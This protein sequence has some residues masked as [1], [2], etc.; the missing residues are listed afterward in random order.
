MPFITVEEA[1]EDFRQG[2][3]V[4]IVDDPDRENEGDLCLV[5]EMVTPAAINFM[6][7][8][9]RG[10]VCT[11]MA[12]DWIDRLSLPSM[13]ASGANSSRFGTA[14][15]ISVEAR[16]GVT[17]GISAYDRA[18][19]IAKLADPESTSADFAMPGHVFPLRARE[20]GVL[21]RGGQTEASVDL[22]RLAGLHPV[23]VICEIMDDDGTMARL[24]RLEQFAKEHAVGIVTVADLIA[25]R[26]IHDATVESLAETVLPTAYGTFRVLAY[27]D[28]SEGDV[29]LAL[30][31]GDLDGPEPVLA[32]VHSE[33]LTGDVFGSR[34][35]DCGEQLEQA[36]ERIGDEGRGVLIYL[37]QEG[38]GIGLLNKLRAYHLQDNG[39]DTVD[40]NLELGLPIDRRDYGRA[41]RMLRDLG[42]SRVQLM[43]N[44]PDKVTGL[45]DLGIDVVERLPLVVPATAQNAHYLEVKQQKMGHLLNIG[46]SL[47]ATRAS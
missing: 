23:A 19:T 30:V 34:R 44:N 3:F 8:E 41:A 2:R 10:L 21:E 35:C 11:P 39:L 5:A 45:T 25:W 26:R 4:I 36:L 13:V 15:T 32:R 46:S 6:A 43:T 31:L 16:E 1:I 7:R 9:A 14:F 17:T 42:V 33:C 24:P 18:V 22:A 47:A 20:G 40:A 28:D 38:R 29:D 12:A 27:G 37:R